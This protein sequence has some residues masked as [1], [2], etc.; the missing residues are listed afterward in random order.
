[1]GGDF[2]EGLSHN[3]GVGNAALRLAPSEVLLD[4]VW[5]D[6]PKQWSQNDPRS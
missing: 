3:R 4:R 2:W 1:M 6:L 5:L